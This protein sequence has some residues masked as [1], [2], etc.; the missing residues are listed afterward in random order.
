MQSFYSTHITSD[1]RCGAE[2]RVDLGIKVREIATWIMRTERESPR[3]VCA[4][5]VVL[6]RITGFSSIV[7]VV[8]VYARTTAVRAR[9]YLYVLVGR[10]V[11][12]VVLPPAVL[13]GW[14]CF[15]FDGGVCCFFFVFGLVLFNMRRAHARVC[16]ISATLCAP[17]GGN[18]FR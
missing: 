4:R 8:F 1:N 13:I 2:R 9:A 18:V 16:G 10:S 5:A 14:W 17:M 6:Y 3:H 15:A 12:N 11:H 7:C